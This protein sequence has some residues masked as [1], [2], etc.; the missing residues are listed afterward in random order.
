MTVSIRAVL[1]I[2]AS[3]VLTTSIILP[4]IA[5]AQETEPGTELYL[6]PGQ[7]N[8]EQG[9]EAYCGLDLSKLQD[10][11]IDKYA[12][13]RHGKLCYQK[14]NNFGGPMF[15]GTKTL[16]AVMLGRA[17][18]L[19]RNIPRTGHATGTISHD[20]RALD[21]LDHVSFHPD[22]TLSHVMSMVAH[23][24]NRFAQPPEPVSDNLVMNY[25]DWDYDTV[26]AVQINEL[27][28]VTYQAVR[29]T[30]WWR[31]DP[32][33]F[34]EDEIFD[35]MGMDDSNFDAVPT[36][37]ASGWWSDL[38]DM[39]KLG[40][41]LLHDGWYGGKR[42]LS[43]EWVYRM[44]H[45]AFENANTGYGHL[46][47]LNHRGNSDGTGGTGDDP[48]AG[49]DIRKYKGD[50]CAPAAVWPASSF[51]HGLSEANNCNAYCEDDLYPAECM[52]AACAQDDDK[53]VGVFAAQGL[54]GQYIVMHP[55]LDMVIV[56]RHFN[57]DPNNP[58]FH[59]MAELWKAVRPALT[60]INDDFG[61]DEAA[62]CE[63]YGA[64]TYAPDLPMP[65]HL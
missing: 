26:G 22:A 36:G 56:A 55:G 39:G 19:T 29:Q 5:D 63:A 15:S 12:I 21:W 31:A 42:L 32:W 23:D 44:S 1:T 9:S 20:D 28:D 61:G 48:D 10:D 46:T 43:R 51:P 8:W 52:V 58:D 37:L 33:S 40:T 7:G 53:D 3:T 14:G 4:T 34:V 62:F 65:R 57:P 18:Y 41:L 49:E 25:G 45:P 2:F 59:G 64:G 50:S 11:D 47:W 24:E 27:L 60:A 6:D 38:H 35:E 13:F 30:R 54:N 16:G 17:A